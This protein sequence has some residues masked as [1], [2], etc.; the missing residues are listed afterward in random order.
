MPEGAWA[1]M[2]W[3]QAMA[4]INHYPASVTAMPLGGFRAHGHGTD[5][6]EEANTQGDA[7]YA[8]AVAL[9]KQENKEGS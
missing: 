3:L 4:R 8:A 1:A 9:Y 5:I 2:E 6:Y 7:V